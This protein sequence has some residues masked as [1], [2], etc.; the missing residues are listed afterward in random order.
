M[1]FVLFLHNTGIDF[2]WPLHV[3]THVHSMLFW[4]NLQNSISADAKKL[5]WQILAWTTSFRGFFLPTLPVSRAASSTCWHCWGVSKLIGYPG[6]LLCQYLL[7]WTST[8]AVALLDVGFVAL[9]PHQFLQSIGE[10][11][12][13]LHVMLLLLLLLHKAFSRGSPPLQSPP[14]QTTHKSMP[15]FPTMHWLHVFFQQMHTNIISHVQ[16]AL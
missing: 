12:V 14:L 2:K 5:F 4:H 1:V 6:Y 3:S 7:S 8:V 11:Q 16:F 9:V 13:Q 10:G 15:F